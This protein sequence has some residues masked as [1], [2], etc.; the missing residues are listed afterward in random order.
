MKKENISDALNYI[1]DNIIESADTLRI[2]NKKYKIMRI[3]R[4]CV[5]ACL[6]VAIGISSVIWVPKLISKNSNPSKN[7]QEKLPLLDATVQFGN[8]GFEGY[9]AHDISELVNANPWYEG[10]EIT[11]LPVYK[12]ALALD[13]KR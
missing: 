10:C 3:A 2:F 8:L 1:D 13:F 12:N 11:T 6:I 4:T 7:S 5:A 9:M